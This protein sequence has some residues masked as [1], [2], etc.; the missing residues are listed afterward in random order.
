MKLAQGYRHPVVCLMAGLL[1]VAL[2][3]SCRAAPAGNFGIYLADSGE[4][5][6]SERDIQSFDSATGHFE[7]NRA[8][9]ER[10]NSFTGATNPPGLAGSLYGQDFIIRIEGRELCRGRFWSSAS[11]MSYSGTIILDALFRL[12]NELNAITLQT[13]YPVGRPDP[14]TG[15]TLAAFFGKKGLLK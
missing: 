3:T 9:I 1:V 13:G 14:E 10:W 4:L 5:V 7:L 11:S 8:G 12:D 15:A 6:L 2:F